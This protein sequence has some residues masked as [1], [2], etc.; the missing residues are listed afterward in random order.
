[1]TD[2]SIMDAVDAYYDE[3]PEDELADSIPTDG[4]LP[5]AYP[6]LTVAPIPYTS[7]ATDHPD[8]FMTITTSGWMFIEV[9]N[10]RLAIPDRQEWDKLVNMGNRMWNTWEANHTGLPLSADRSGAACP[11][12]GHPFG[13]LANHKCSIPTLAFVDEE[14]PHHQH[15]AVDGSTH[16]GPAHPC[17]SCDAMEAAPPP[18]GVQEATAAA[19]GGVIAPKA[20]EQMIHRATAQM[21]DEGETDDPGNPDRDH[22]R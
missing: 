14:P 6:Q 3:H 9:G 19:I 15:I 10:T 16:D 11:H 4:F 8:P 1:M 21:A 17:P 7:Q 20:F 18:S 12:C 13:N 5:E 22:P 2:D